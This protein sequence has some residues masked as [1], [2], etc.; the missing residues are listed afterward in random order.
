MLRV[1]NLDDTPRIPPASNWGSAN[2]DLLLGPDDSEWQKSPQFRIFPN[3]LLVVLL[4]IIG[5]I[6]DRDLVMV[7]I[8]HDLLSVELQG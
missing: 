3:S 5:E 6:V 8:L 7:N 4:D 2:H 1:I